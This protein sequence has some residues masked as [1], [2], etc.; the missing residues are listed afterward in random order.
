MLSRG[1]NKRSVSLSNEPQEDLPSK[2]VEMNK[3]IVADLLVLIVF[4][5]AIFLTFYVNLNFN[6]LVAWL[7]LIAIIAFMTLY[8]GHRILKSWKGVFVDQLNK[9]SLVRFQII[10]WTILVLATFGEAAL[11]NIA[12]G[13]PNP[14]FTV[15]IPSNLWLVMG[16]SFAAL[17][18]ASAASIHKSNPSDNEKIVNAI[19][20]RSLKDK[21]E[22]LVPLEELPKDVKE[23]ADKAFPEGFVNPTKKIW[24]LKTVN[25]LK[26]NDDYLIANGLIVARARSELAR[27]KDM[28]TGDEITNFNYVDISKAQLFL[29]NVLLIIVFSVALGSYF[30]GQPPFTTL[31]NIPDLVAIFLGISNGTY[32]TFKAIP[33]AA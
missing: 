15:I 16:I 23:I 4:A 2:D 24:E 7:V 21:T 11:A 27:F 14:I 19:G 20:L 33:R 25:Y 32:V 22:I 5:F 12:N 13:G 26:I 8:I 29:F 28:F 6:R 10:I 31:P 30:M 3:D 18:V 9:V 1:K 17:P